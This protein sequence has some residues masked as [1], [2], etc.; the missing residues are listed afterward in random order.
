MVHSIFSNCGHRRCSDASAR[1]HKQVTGL[2]YPL[3]CSKY[4]TLL[5]HSLLMSQV[6]MLDFR[7]RRYEYLSGTTAVK[8]ERYAVRCHISLASGL[9]HLLEVTLGTVL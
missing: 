3:P 7:E 4:D 1:R 9:W 6:V 5:E 8:I 2:F